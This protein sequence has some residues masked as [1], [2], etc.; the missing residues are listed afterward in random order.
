MDSC[1]GLTNPGEQ[2]K[3]IPILGDIAGK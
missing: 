3:S 2:K 1:F